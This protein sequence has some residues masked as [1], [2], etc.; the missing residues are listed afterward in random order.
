[1]YFL[2]HKFTEA[3]SN[4]NNSR[5]TVVVSAETIVGLR[6]ERVRSARRLSMVCAQTTTVKRRKSVE[7]RT[8]NTTTRLYGTTTRRQGRAMRT[9][10]AAKR[11]KNMTKHRKC[12]TN[13]TKRRAKHRKRT[14]NRTKKRRQAALGL[15][16]RIMVVLFLDKFT[17]YLVPS[18]LWLPS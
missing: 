3:A 1:M 6:G 18:L 12:A 13:R 10:Y 2:S 4:A 9:Y 11:T 8:K 5:F 16:P 17:R 14:T 7:K 15:P